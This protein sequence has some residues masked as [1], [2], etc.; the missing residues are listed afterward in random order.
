MTQHCDTIRRTRPQTPAWFAPQHIDTRI[1]SQGGVL[2]LPFPAAAP[3]GRLRLLLTVFLLLLATAM[4]VETVRWPWSNDAQVFHYAI[5]LMS[6]G[7]AP[8][9]QIIDLNLPGSYLSEWIGMHLVPF[10]PIV[11]VTDLSYRLYDLL[12][13]ALFG[14]AA[15]VITRPYNWFAGV[16]AATLFALLHASEGAWMLG[17]RDFVM[18]VL[19]AG[20][21]AFTFSATRSAS[22]S[23]NKSTVSLFLGALLLALACTL[24][25]FALLYAVP[26]FVSPIRQSARTLAPIAAAFALVAFLTLGFLLWR[27]SLPAFLSSLQLAAGYSSTHRTSLAYMLHHSTPRGLYLLLPPAFVLAALHRSWRIPEVL[28]LQLATLLGLF[29]YFVQNKGFIYHRYPWVAF[30]LLWLAVE[31]TLA[32]SNAAQ[33]RVP[34]TTLA[35]T[36]AA[37]TLA[38]ATFLVA[39]FYLYR[40]FH[41]PPD[42]A[43]STAIAQDLRTLQRNGVPLDTHIQCLDGITGCYSALYRLQLA[44]STGFMGDQLL[45]QATSTPAVQR[46]RAL[47]QQQLAGNPPN[48]FV[49]TN[50]WYG[51]PQQFTKIATWP[52]FQSWL[53]ANY[54]LIQ[55]RTFPEHPGD[56]DPIGYQIYLRRP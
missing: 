47:F 8:Y 25:P 7:L 27:N 12:L 22:G 4:V 41:M 1:P 54:T 44:S 19:L 39:P 49:E 45:F 5:F 31:C 30:A 24:K 55:T 38:A 34:S 43:M 32:V 48:V 10:S 42:T 6:R 2:N 3:T 11:Q 16:L 15:V 28:N 52:A 29:S 9:R 53:H 20:A 13:L 26:L 51:G 37:A 56:I 23:G 40:T 18:A 36:L 35:A 33:S 21:Y 46:A 17:E 50:Y 14:W